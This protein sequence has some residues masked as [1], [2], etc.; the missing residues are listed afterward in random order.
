[1]CPWSADFQVC[2]HHGGK[3]RICVPDTTLPGFVHVMCRECYVKLHETSEQ[4][5]VC[6]AR[7]GSER[8][9]E[10]SFAFGCEERSSIQTCKA[11]GVRERVVRIR[12]VMPEGG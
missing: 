3:V 4:A 2:L 6:R 8:L 5:G 10:V 1:M 11:V 9:E 7:T 12:G